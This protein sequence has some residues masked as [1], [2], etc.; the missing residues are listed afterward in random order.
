MASHI[1]MSGSPWSLHHTK[2]PREVHESGCERDRTV[3]SSD[4]QCY[5]HGSTS[6]YLNKSCPQNNVFLPEV[7]YQTHT[8]ILPG[9]ADWLK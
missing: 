8:S 5:T 9:K 7:P 1:C 4:H 3:H 2:L 6:H